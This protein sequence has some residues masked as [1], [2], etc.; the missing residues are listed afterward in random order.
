MNSNFKPI[1]EALIKE[2]FYQLPEQHPKTG[3]AF[4]FKITPYSLNTKLSFKF[5]SMNHFLEFLKLSEPELSTEKQEI[6]Q[7][8]FIELGL[9]SE[10]FFYVNFYEKE[11]TWKCDYCINM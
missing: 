4:D 5:E 2:G 11:K 6:L 1:L 10:D 3:K 8:T 9:S 7:T